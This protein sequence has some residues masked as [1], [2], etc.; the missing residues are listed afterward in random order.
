MKKNLNLL[1]L[2]VGVALVLLG[3]WGI[4]FYFVITEAREIAVVSQETARMEKEERVAE[5][6]RVSVE[7]DLASH[8]RVD[9]YFVTEKTLV[10]SIE[11]LELAA[12]RAGVSIIIDAFDPDEKKN[13]V[14]IDVTVRGSYAAVFRFVSALETSPHLFQ[15]N[16]IAVARAI[17]K[18]NTE[19]GAKITG[20]MYAY[21]GHI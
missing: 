16:D 10:S 21:E 18:G 15:L 3:A 14:S 2:T 5:E 13:E 7:K 1:S 19:W 4:M 20:T 8:Q 6:M 11:N 12:R 17:G 9:S